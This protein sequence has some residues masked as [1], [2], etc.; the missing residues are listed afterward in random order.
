MLHDDSERAL[1]LCYAKQKKKYI[2]V[3]IWGAL[4][5]HVTIE[6]ATL[7]ITSLAQHV[8]LCHS[9]FFLFNSLFF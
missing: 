2:Y 7:L 3:N 1:Y 4:F 6:L 9:K 5:A 8:L